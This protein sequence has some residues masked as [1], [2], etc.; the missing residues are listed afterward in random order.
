[1]SEM[2]PEEEILVV[3][4]V[5][6]STRNRLAQMTLVNADLEGLLALE[7]NKNKEL[8]EHLQKISEKRD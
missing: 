6:E 3:K 2:L 5:L 1:M 7:R 8:L 4:S